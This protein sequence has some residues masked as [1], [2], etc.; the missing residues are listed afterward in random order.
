MDF[1]AVRHFSYD[2]FCYPLDADS[3]QVNVQTGSD[4][5]SVRLVYGDPFKGKLD[6]GKWSWERSRAGKCPG[7]GIKICSD[8]DKLSHLR[9]REKRI[10]KCFNGHIFL[11]TGNQKL[12]LKSGKFNRL[13][14]QKFAD[15]F[16][17]LTS[18]A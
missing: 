18:G 16:N 5:L 14:R 15:I 9:C 2:S 7:S 3:L 4:V 10:K 11:F 1:S 13:F 12:S 6:G 17:I 8:T